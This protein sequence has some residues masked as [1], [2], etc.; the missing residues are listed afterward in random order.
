MEDSTK[1]TF[2]KAGNMRA[3]TKIQLCDMVVNSWNKISTDIVEKSF[4]S[5]GESLYT[6]VEMISCFQDGKSCAEGRS[7]LEELMSV[8]IDIVDLD[9]RETTTDINSNEE[10]YEVY[11]KE[12]IE[13]GADEAHAP[14]TS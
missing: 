11:I 8:D 3:P 4:L 5:C 13:D 2:T 7:R 10:N 6:Q 1:H 12:E 14:L 9:L